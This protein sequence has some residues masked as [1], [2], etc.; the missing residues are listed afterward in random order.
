[1]SI[2]IPDHYTRLADLQDELNRPERERQAAERMLEMQ[3]QKEN[4]REQSQ[5]ERRLPVNMRYA[6][7]YLKDAFDEARVRPI[8]LAFGYAAVQ[9]LGQK[10]ILVEDYPTEGE[11]MTRDQVIAEWYEGYEYAVAHKN[12]K[13]DPEEQ[14]RIRDQDRQERLQTCLVYAQEH[15]GDLYDEA[16]VRPIVEAF[17]FQA[18]VSLLADFLTREVREEVGEGGEQKRKE[19]IGEWYRVC[20]DLLTK[21]EQPEKS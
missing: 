18:I 1:M 13:V 10:L 3:R 7:E 17:G 4:E 12:D 16:R 20:E 19:L 11:T 6:R 8:L 5:R 2:E 9:S 14:Q 15:L 21:N